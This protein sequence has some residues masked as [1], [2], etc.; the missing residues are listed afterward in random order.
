VIDFSCLIF[1]LQVI[2]NLASE[3]SSIASRGTSVSTTATAVLTS[4]TLNLGTNGKVIVS[5]VYKDSVK[6][7]IL[8]DQSSQGG[9]SVSS[10]VGSVLNG[11]AT[12]PSNA[13]PPAT[14]TV[15]VTE[16]FYKYSPITPVGHF[17]NTSGIPTQLYD[18]AYY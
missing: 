1:D 10:K 13:T 16:I 14:Q 12:L 7:L 9:L 2:A 5:A 3:G 4:S 11:A 17:I 6:G 15:Y 18:I 8:T